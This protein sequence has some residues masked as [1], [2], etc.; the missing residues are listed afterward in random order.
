M[1]SKNK[2]DFMNEFK[3]LI[4]NE[5]KENHPV[6]G[7]ITKIEDEN[8]EISIEKPINIS[9]NIPIKIDHVNAQLIKNKYK[10][11]HVQIDENDEFTLFQNVKVHNSQRTIIIKKLQEIL[12][13]I[14]ENK[15]NEENLETLNIILDDYNPKFKKIRYQNA[16]LNSNQSKAIQNSLSSNKFHLI[17]GPPGTGKTHTIIRLVEQLY[18]KGNKILITAHTHIAIDNIL[19]RLVDIPDN[20]ILRLGQ[21]VKIDKNSYKY[22]LNNQI[23]NHRA[24]TKIQD[25][26]KQIKELSISNKIINPQTTENN[27]LSF[28]LNRLIGKKE[29]SIEYQYDNND[30]IQE[31]EDEIESIKLDLR[32]NI[33]KT[34][35]I[36]ATTVLSSSN[37]LTKDLEFDYD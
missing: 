2:Q 24:Y 33:I 26:E 36:I 14:Q 17:Q 15:L 34:S 28:L 19:E 6:T 13:N 29:Q 25:K 31:L 8:L 4:Q 1:T 9:N 37:Y 12:N 7:K 16:R 11:L 21:K 10:K 20:E 35:S 5:I 32:K 22:T 27:K 23:K 18:K 30:K 3:Q